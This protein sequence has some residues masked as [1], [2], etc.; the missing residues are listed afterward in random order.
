MRP[1]NSGPYRTTSEPA[2]PLHSPDWTGI[3]RKRR[4]AAAS[5]LIVLPGYLVADTHLPKP[6]AVL[7]F[8]ALGVVAFACL[9]RFAL[10]KC[11]ACKREFSGGPRFVNPFRAECAHCG[12]SLSGRGGR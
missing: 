3:R 12:A 1:D 4:I 7:V 6:A 9:F 5:A 10:S 2:R 11:P 8:F